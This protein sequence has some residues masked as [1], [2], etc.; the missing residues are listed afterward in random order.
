MMGQNKLELAVS[1]LGVQE[2]YTGGMYLDRDFVVAQFRARHVCQ[3]QRAL[4]SISIE[5]KCFHDDFANGTASSRRS[6]RI[7]ES[8]RP[9]GANLRSN[10]SR[11]AT[12][13]AV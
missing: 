10:R 7:P 6:L 3:P 5:N 11:F 4:L 2:V 13:P 12:L 8:S 1:N 9:A